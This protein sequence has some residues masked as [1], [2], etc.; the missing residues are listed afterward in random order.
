MSA[1]RADYWG[2]P[3]YTKA[4]V[5]KLTS[6]AY[7]QK[8]AA[9]V[10]AQTI[11]PTEHVKPGLE[12]AHTTHFSILDKDGNAV[13]NTYTLN[14][15][16]GN[17]VVVEGAGFLLNDEMDDF[18]AKAGAANIF[19]VV[20]SDANAIEPGKRMLSSMSPTI[21]TQDGKVNLVIGTPGGSRIFTSIFQVINNLYDYNLPLQ[22]A[23]DAQRFHHQ[24]LP[25]DVIYYDDFAPITGDVA[26]K[27]TAMGYKVEDQGWRLGDIQAIQ[28]KNGKTTAASDRR[29]R[30]HNAVIQP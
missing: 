5:K 20:G 30:G 7:L 24:L 27:L 29:G 19:G 3:D 4:P 6:D 18:S 12:P 28:V 11:S 14:W 9:E 26:A 15:D 2:D 16:Y 1:D 22:Q 21:M 25:K 10:N 23:V 13:A 17:G 8:R